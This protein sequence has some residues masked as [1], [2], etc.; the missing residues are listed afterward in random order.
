MDT[1]QLKAI[2]NEAYRQWF[3]ANNPHLHHRSPYHHPAWLAA[4][5][6]GTRFTT[7]FIGVFAGR[8]MVAAVPGFLTGRAPLRLFGSPLRG[9]M[10]SYLGPT[11]LEPITSTAAWIELAEQCDALARREWR[12]GS[13]RLTMRNLPAGEELV[14]PAG[15]KRQRPG[16]YRL[17]LQGGEEALWKGLKSDCRR[18]IRRAQKA[19]MEI[20]PL[21]DAGLY[22]QMIA[23]TFQRHGTTSWHKENFFQALL[24]TLVPRDLLW[25][26][27]VRHEG[28]IIAAGLFLHDDREVHFISGASQPQFGSLPTSYLLHWQAIQTGAAQGLQVFNS[29]ASRVPSIDKFKESFRPDLERRFTLLCTPGYVRLAQKAFQSSYSRL[30][31]VKSRLQTGHGRPELSGR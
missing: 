16:S 26:W 10:T 6:H 28:E 18:N 7:C 2:S 14:L 30:Q 11:S 25:A 23:A 29:D 1:R 3:E 5:A 27:G 13:T 24:A 15:W 4:V 31:A 17:A 20:V 8:Q 9:T 21:E 19:G 22:Y 12:A